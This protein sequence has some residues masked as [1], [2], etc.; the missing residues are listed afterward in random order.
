MC[1][2]DGGWVIIT[3]R[4]LQFK[5][6]ELFLKAAALMLPVST[7]GKSGPASREALSFNFSIQDAGLLA[8]PV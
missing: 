5:Q 8:V 1:D 6:G 7:L 3:G 2:P 4:L